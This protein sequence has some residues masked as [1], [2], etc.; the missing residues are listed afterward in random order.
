MNILLLGNKGYLG[1][2]LYSNLPVDILERRTE[3]IYA[4]GKRYNYVVNCIGKPDVVYCE[5]YPD[6]SNYSNYLVIKDIHRYY[7]SAKI[8]NFSSYYV[9]YDDGLCSEQANTTDAYN[10]CRQKLLGEK[11]IQNGVSF[12]LGKLFGNI[13]TNQNKL[14][15]HIL[16]QNEVTLDSILFNPTSVEQVLRVI[17]YEL[18][19]NNLYGVYN[20]ANKGIV[21][22]SEYGHFIDTYLQTNKKIHT[23]HKIARTFPNYG[24]FLMSV[25]KLN[26]VVPLIDWRSDM[27]KYLHKILLNKKNNNIIT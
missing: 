5:K 15:E 12:R 19:N 14:T 25:E 17:T 4:N 16:S 24:R 11:E 9:Y 10:Y 18:A 23:V 1:S 2:Y 8:I 27:E 13:E 22:H 20:L 6:E 26:G 21:S 3:K 7:P